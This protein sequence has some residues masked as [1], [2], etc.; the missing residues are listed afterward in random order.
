[1]SR[2]A[3][4]EIE[5]RRI[6]VELVVDGARAL[7][8][9]HI[10]GFEPGLVGGRARCDGG[11]HRAVRQNV[12]RVGRLHSLQANPDPWRADRAMCQEVVDDARDAVD[13][14]REPEPDRAAVWR[15]DIAVHTDHFTVS[16][17]QGTAGIAGV[18]R[19]VGLNHVEVGALALAGR[20]EVALRGADDADAYAR[21]AVA[22]V[23]AIRVAD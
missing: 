13:R 11:D 9:N 12:A 23:K 8:K 16:V 4:A 1:M 21:L 14:N 17:D 5:Q 2:R 22:E 15:E 3:D 7:A 6:P 20:D 18:D 19:R 10:S